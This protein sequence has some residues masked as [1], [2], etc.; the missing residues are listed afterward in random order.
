MITIKE[1]IT[2]YKEC[3]DLFDDG[4]EKYKFLID[5]AKNATQFP[6]EYRNDSF[7][8]SGCQA[9]VW[10]VPKLDENK[11]SFYYDSDA[12][13]SKGMVTILCDIYGDRK[14]SEII[15]SDFE[16]LNILALDTLLTPG[17]RNGVYSMLEKIKEYANSYS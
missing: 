3:L 1:K 13:I 12:F 9:Q 16:M 17:R 15:N 14:P 6:E 5:Q 8:V 4:M 7:K 10:L 2:Y 11:L